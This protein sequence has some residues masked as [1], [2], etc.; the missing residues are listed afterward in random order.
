MPHFRSPLLFAAMLAA[1]LAA[2]SPLPGAGS[3]PAVDP[4]FDFTEIESPAHAY[5]TR[6]LGDP[7][8]L[9]LERVRSGETALDTTSEKAFL[10]ALLDALDIPQSSQLIV[11]SATS[12]QITKITPNNPRAIY[13][14]EDVSVGYIPGGRIEVLSLDP[15]AGGIFYI[16]DIPTA[17]GPITA[18]RTNRCMNCHVATDTRDVP[19]Y[20]IKSVM[21]GPNGGS[22]DGFRPADSGHH[23]PLADR[24]GGWHLTG[25]GRLKNDHANRVGRFLRGD[26]ETTEIPFGTRFDLDRYLVP[27]S[28]LL[29]H[30]I[31]EH[32][33]GFTNRCLET[34]YL[35][36]ALAASPTPDRE[37]L[38]EQQAALLA[39]YL[40]FAG[41]AALPDGGVGGTPDY[42]EA[43][44]AKKRPDSAGRSLRDFDLRSRLFRYRCSYM[45]Y[46]NV[47]QQGLSAAMKS[48]VYRHLGD[49]LGNDAPSDFSYLPPAERE[50]IKSILRE[51][52]P[53]R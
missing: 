6:P 43:F 11:F 10:A 12:L 25:A 8:T 32:Q 39:R 7:F 20:T 14:N 49:A 40:L 16:F 37:R 21:R 44:T 2:A 33:A 1:I 42:L 36:R 50:A 15:A 31:H 29:P 46:E 5:W 22:L 4:G 9:L 28:D 45:I 17:P 26:I 38:L 23:I 3:E 41:E 27:T 48:R 13:F 18:E 24:F 35:E 47:F 19:G 51:T 30:L 52:L 34:I 53:D